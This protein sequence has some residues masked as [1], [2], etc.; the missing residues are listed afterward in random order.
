[1]TK[2]E[3]SSQLRYML[4]KPAGGFM[5]RAEALSVMNQTGENGKMAEVVRILRGKGDKEFEIF[6]EMLQRSNYGVWANRLRV[7]A[8]YFQ[9]HPQLL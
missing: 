8:A 6:C 9:M 1:M 2:V 3:V 5:S 4:E 7:E